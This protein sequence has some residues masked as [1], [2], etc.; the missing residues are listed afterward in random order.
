MI[1][2]TIA[3]LLMLTTIGIYIYI[4]AVP[5]LKGSFVNDDK[6]TEL[7]WTCKPGAHCCRDPREGDAF[8][9]TKECSSMRLEVPTDEKIHFFNTYLLAVA[10]TLV[11]LLIV[12]YSQ[13]RIT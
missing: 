8:C 13:T 5:W 2:N 11:V 4:F 9:V 6:C 7:G 1:I 10:I 3:V 12:K